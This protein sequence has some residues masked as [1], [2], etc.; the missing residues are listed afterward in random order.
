LYNEEE[1]NFK[2]I[3]EAKH[4][5]NTEKRQVS[6]NLIQIKKHKKEDALS[7]KDQH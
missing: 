7:E 1:M 5:K 3:V 6:K 4:R 2:R